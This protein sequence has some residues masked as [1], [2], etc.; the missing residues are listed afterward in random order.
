MSGM[1]LSRDRLAHF[2]MVSGTCWFFLS[3]FHCSFHRCLVIS[4]FP[5][6]STLICNF[7]HFYRVQAWLTVDGFGANADIGQWL[8]N[9]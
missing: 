9:P 4:A 6:E 3:S 2:G 7:N 5:W 8:I 1:P